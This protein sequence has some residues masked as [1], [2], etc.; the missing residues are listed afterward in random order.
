[1]AEGSRGKLLLRARASEEWSL[2]DSVLTCAW[3]GESVEAM[4]FR[5]SEL[6]VERMGDGESEE[7]EMEI[8]RG[9][10]GCVEGLGEMAMASGWCGQCWGRC[11]WA[12]FCESPTLFL[13]DGDT[14]T[15][16]GQE[17]SSRLRRQPLQTG[18]SSLHFFLRRRHVKQPVRDRMMGKARMVWVWLGGECGGVDEV[19]ARSEHFFRATKGEIGL[20]WHEETVCV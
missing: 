16:A 11:C 6:G 8:A 10:G 9:W 14:A 2:S 19:M 3:T 20:V 13:R 18:F 12:V 7:E 15:S 5:V 17:H 1:M 4:E